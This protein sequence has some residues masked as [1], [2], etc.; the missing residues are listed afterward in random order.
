MKDS[1]TV[2]LGLEE[3]GERP[4]GAV[5]LLEAFVQQVVAHSVFVAVVCTVG[6]SQRSALGSLHHTTM[7]VGGLID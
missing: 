5:L 1:R 7:V 4:V 2:E 3:F 6:T